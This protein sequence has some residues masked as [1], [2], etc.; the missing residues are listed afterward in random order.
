MGVIESVA[1]WVRLFDPPGPR[2]DLLAVLP[3][4]GPPLAEYP[5]HIGS[6]RRCRRG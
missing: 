3:E 5:V 4:Q 1:G 6:G 2:F